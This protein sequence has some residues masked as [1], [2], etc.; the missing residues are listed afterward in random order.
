MIFLYHCIIQYIFVAHADF[1]LIKDP[2]Q[3]ALQNINMQ[4]LRK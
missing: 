2:A 1:R 4:S 3:L